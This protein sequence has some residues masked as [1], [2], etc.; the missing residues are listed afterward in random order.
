[1]QN[2]RNKK[3]E[4]YWLKYYMRDHCVLCGNYGVL[5]T[6]GV[7]T[8]SGVSCGAVVFCICPN[9]Q[10]MRIKGGDPHSQLKVK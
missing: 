3:V 5:D 8:P 9:G 2:R 7:K 4:E 1:M 10:I 6:R